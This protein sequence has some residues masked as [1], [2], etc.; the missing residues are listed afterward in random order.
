MQSNTWSK[1]GLRF[2]HNYITLIYLPLYG[3]YLVMIGKEAMVLI[4]YFEIPACCLI[5][6]ISIIY[7]C[8]QYQAQSLLPAC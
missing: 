6:E 5:L 8:C 3:N 1:T 2:L 7:C 4:W